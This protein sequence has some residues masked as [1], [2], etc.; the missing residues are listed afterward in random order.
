MHLTLPDGSEAWLSSLSTLKWPSV[1][2]SD[3][4][5]VVLDGEG[6]FTVTKDASRPFTVQTQKYDVRVLGTEFNVYAYGN[7][8]KFETDLLSGKVQVIS[9]EYPEETITLM[10][11]EKV[12]LVEGKLM[13][14]VSH[15]E[16]K[17]YREQGIYDFEEKPLGEVL[18]RLEQWY[19]VSF[20][21][22]N[23]SLLDK[24]ISGKF[25]QSDQIETILKAISRAGLFEYKIISLRE[26]T[27]Y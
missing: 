20:V 1:F 17:E 3:A 5:T 15:F 10:P 26:I 25:R 2:S 27:I 24:I 14:S 6:F 4:R 9:A 21:V 12:S 23:P 19:D 13:K 7:S 16:G 11:N 22:D 8:Q 18:E